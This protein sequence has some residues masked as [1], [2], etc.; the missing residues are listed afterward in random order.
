MPAQDPRPVLDTA[1][2]PSRLYRSDEIA[3]R[4]GWRPAGWRAARRAGLK[5]L[6]YGKRFFVKG[7]DLIEFI[8][9]QADRGE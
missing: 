9:E 8:E 6:R 4:M 5:A 3:T 7:A 1:I 2:D